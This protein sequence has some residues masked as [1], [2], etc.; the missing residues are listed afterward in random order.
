MDRI[1]ID[2][3]LLDGQLLRILGSA[4]HGGADIGECLAAARL[5]DPANLDSWYEQW[6]ALGQ[7]VVDLA[8][9]A[10]AAGHA[11]TARLAYLRG[12][13]Y[14]RAGGSM[15]MGAPV[16]PRLVES[17]LRRPTPSKRR[18]TA[19]HPAG[20]HRD[21]L[22]G[23][24][25]ARLLLR[26]R[27]I[28]PADR[29]PCRRVR[30]L[31]RGALLL[32]RRIRPGARLQ[33]ARIRRSGQARHFR[34]QGLVMRPDWENVI[35]PVVDYLL[36]RREVD[37]ERIA[38]IGLSLG[39]TWSRAR[40]AVSTGSLPASPTA[41]RST[42]TAP[43]CPDYPRR[44]GRAT[45]RVTPKRCGCGGDVDQIAMQPTAGWSMRRGMLVHGATSAHEYIEMTKPVLLRGLA[46][47]ITCPTFVCNAENDPIG[48]TA[49]DLVAALTCPHEFVT[50]TA[51]EG[52]GDHCEA[53]ARLLYDARS[54][55]WLD[56]VRESL[57][58]GALSKRA[59]RPSS[60]QS[61]RNGTP[62]K[63]LFGPELLRKMAVS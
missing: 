22:R 38:V 3:D 10:A 20:D 56:G 42:C 46:E 11:Q 55:G 35:A 39:H 40:P 19:R 57:A 60:A 49:P 18:R 29:H 17:N 9:R 30:R 59:P 24:D 31:R 54:L 34:Q 61:R 4:P 14:L 28:G 1:A 43:S 50:F 7:R 15:L 48:A 12:S 27:H 25:A 26:N 2:D 51:A 32:Q 41:G 63:P 23:H 44:C 33:R 8:D 13:N 6:T 36:Q 52:A 47:R 45:K 5:I 62:H 37:A 21:R 53:G 16:D 58:T